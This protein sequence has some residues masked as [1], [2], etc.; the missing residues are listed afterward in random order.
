MKKYKNRPSVKGGTIE[1]NFSSRY[2]INLKIL[3]TTSDFAEAA[4]KVM[5]GFYESADNIQTHLE[6]LFLL[7]LSINRLQAGE[8]TGYEGPDEI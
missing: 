2:G 6:Y 1:E 7:H 4:F 5:N 3:K 8:E